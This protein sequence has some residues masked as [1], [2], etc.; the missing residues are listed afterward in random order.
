MQGIGPGTILSGRY[1][2]EH[3][4]AAYQGAE[5]WTARDSTLDRSVL[6]LA[7]DR[8]HPNV[9]AVL[10]AARRTA[11]LDNVRLS[12]I[13]DVGTDDGLAYVVEEAL[14]GS[15]TISQLLA[16]GPLPAPEV[17]RVV[18]ETSLVL[19][20]A[21]HRGLH[22][23]RLTPDLVLRTPDGDVKLRGL[24]TMAALAGVDDVP[25]Q[26]A[27]HTDAIAVVALAYA[28]FTLSLIHI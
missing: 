21:R 5:Q 7:V 19:D 23:Q 3:R 20:V 11:G 14:E 13:L 17:R 4:T 28:G 15:Q 1:T 8:K 18:G 16:A 6:L 22:H 2:A 25:D 12:R 27:A 24:A 26:E 10:D 9:D